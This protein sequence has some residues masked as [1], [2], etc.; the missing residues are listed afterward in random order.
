M[1]SHQK[2]VVIFFVLSLILAGSLIYYGLPKFLYPSL[3]LD[4]APSGAYVVPW[5]RPNP[6]IE[7]LNYYPQLP[8][9]PP[10]FDV[11]LVMTDALK[12]NMTFR[13]VT[14]SDV[15]VV[16]SVVYL[17]HDADHLYV[18][19]K[20]VGMYG[21]PDTNYP[22]NVIPNLFD[23]LFD[24]ENDGVLKSP[25]SGSRFAAYVH[26]ERA[27]FNV[28]V[29]MLWFDDPP[30]GRAS[31]TDVDWYAGEILHRALPVSEDG[32][33]TAYYNSTGTLM[34]IY[35]RL[36]RLSG[37]AEVNAL[38]MRP[39]ERW[40]MGFLL[41]LGYQSDDYRI[42]LYMDG[43]PQNIYPYVSDDS[44]WWPKL[45]IDLANPPASFST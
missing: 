6:S 21:N 35:S 13:I 38:Q 37:N 1:H 18:A 41:Q 24:V 23:I 16:P 44:S 32:M 19:G 33:A 5:M 25:E 39:G 9:S 7:E 30:D 26:Q 17:G 15:R 36:L 2:Q 8:Y 14:R 4:S 22:E 31:W 29:D 45:V 12:L 40:T 11:D 34:I 43:W 27:G 28:Y 42:G 3:R 20:F 10:T